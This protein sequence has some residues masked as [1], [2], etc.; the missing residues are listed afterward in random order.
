MPISGVRSL[1]PCLI[2]KRNGITKE[3]GER[4]LG[5]M[6]G[7]QNPQLLQCSR[8]IRREFKGLLFISQVQ[9][10]NRNLGIVCKREYRRLEGE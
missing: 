2:S 1:G 10:G 5:S 4:G 9:D 8:D 3:A 6:A 7:R